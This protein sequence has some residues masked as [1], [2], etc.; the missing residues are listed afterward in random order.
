MLVA[1]ALFFI[2]S[3]VLNITSFGITGKTTE[4]YLE[5]LELYDCEETGKWDKDNS[6]LKLTLCPDDKPIMRGIGIAVTKDYQSGGRAYCCKA[7]NIELYDCREESFWE[8]DSQ[9]YKLTYCPTQSIMKGVG[10]GVKYSHQSGGK[11]Y[12][13]KA[14]N[15]EL[16][17][18]AVTSYWKDSNKDYKLTL[19]PEDR[20]ILVGAGVNIKNDNQG[21][22]KAYCCKGKTKLESELGN[23]EVKVEEVLEEPSK[24]EISE[25]EIKEEEAEKVEEESFL[26]ILEKLFC[27]VLYRKNIEKY[28]SCIQ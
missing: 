24:T 8:E 15:L 28:K 12:C 23:E 21:G 4:T 20:Q 22:G 16:Y 11:A 3:D 9:D 26:D 17:S 5:D 18:C 19:C 2:V 25:E 14:K 13:C 10:F 27:K 1:L 6:N 7:K